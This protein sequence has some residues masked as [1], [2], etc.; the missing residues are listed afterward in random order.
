M[1]I[2]DVLLKILFLSLPGIISMIVF[3][4]LKANK[5]K[6]DWEDFIEIFLFAI[7]SYF[8]YFG[9]IF[10]TSNKIPD[11]I[12]KNIFESKILVFV[13]K[14]EDVVELEN[15]Y[16]YNSLNDLYI[17]DKTISYE[18]YMKV[19]DVYF[20]AK[21]RVVLLFSASI[22]DIYKYWDIL[23][24]ICLVGI[25]ISIIVSYFHNYKL[26]NKIGRLLR[27]TRSFGD[28][29]VWEFL[30]NSP[31]LAWVYLRDLTNDLTY[32][33][34]VLAFST[35][36]KKRELLLGAVTVFQGSTSEKLY[37]MEAIYLSKDDFDFVL[38][39]PFFSDTIPEKIEN[40]IYQE[41][42]ENKMN[43]YERKLFLSSYLKEGEYFII[44]EKSN[45]NKK[46]KIRRIFEKIGYNVLKDENID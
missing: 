13:E 12:Q 29:N 39:M 21:S 20:K 43:N 40:K 31:E 19:R 45:Y 5:I 8:I 30:N 2:N 6:K 23:L 35:S 41:Q 33:G 28:E 38:E 44:K 24:Y 36:D 1:E 37:N 46:L 17:L 42:I 9:I 11:E 10:I 14:S 27:V 25:L 32:Y 34:R 7:L 18:K 22:T 3:R 15:A 26:I 4:Q 16:I